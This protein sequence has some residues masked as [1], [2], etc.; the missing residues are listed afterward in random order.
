MDNFEDNNT[1]DLGD[2]DE[3]LKN[4]DDENKFD[5]KDD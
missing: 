4:N 1:E 3:G 2:Y 5:E